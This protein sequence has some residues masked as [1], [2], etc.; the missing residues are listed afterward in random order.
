MKSRFTALVLALL[1]LIPSAVAVWSYVS[2][3]NAPLTDDVIDTIGISDLDGRS[4]TLK[5]D[6][7]SE[8]AAEMFSA[9]L[10]ANKNSESILGGLP[11][12]LI[13]TKFYSVSFY[14]KGDTK[15]YQY[16]FSPSSTDAYYL[17]EKAQAYKLPTDFVNYFHASDYSMSLYDT[18]HGPVLTV[19]GK[20]VVAAKKINWQYKLPDGS[21]SDNCSLSSETTEG[22]YF[23]DDGIKLSFTY[24]P[25]VLN[26]KVL[27]GSTVIFDD[28]YSKLTPFR[29]EKSRKVSVELDASWYKDE[30]RDYYGDAKYSFS[31]E[32]PAVADFAVNKTQIEPGD[33]VLVSV[34]N[35]YDASKLS[36][37]CDP[38]IS[39]EPRFFLDGTI[40][41]ALVPISYELSDGN[42]AMTLGYGQETRKYD[43]TVS[44]KTFKRVPVAISS[45]VEK[46]TRT[47]ETLKEFED[48]LGPIASEGSSTISF[49]N[50][51]FRDYTVDDKGF[52]ISAG[53]GVT[54]TISPSGTTYRHNGVDFKTT[55]GA[56]VPAVMDGE[57]VYT[58]STALSGNLIVIEHGLGLKSWYAHLGEISVKTGD[59]IEKGQIIAKTGATGFTN[60]TTLHLGLTVFDVPVSIYPLWEEPGLEVVDPKQ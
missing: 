45:E 15:N 52:A 60:G 54:K 57:V 58:G 5:R 31:T 46:A 19:G 48:T 20:Y 30:S 26:V 49:T 4:Y 43:I 7:D 29:F 35:V 27:D 25:D 53:I 21:Y 13:G 51:K 6:D 2:T 10:E 47:E 56:D 8:P 59:K 39:Y 44:P 40:A 12:P 14:G 18:A 22:E 1:L 38:D 11:E 3:N 42:Y 37:S 24:E 41:R 28:E 34:S 33:F 9:I 50:G 23:L 36:F 17:D 55:G 16:Y 32:V